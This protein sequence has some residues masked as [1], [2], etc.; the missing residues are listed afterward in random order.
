MLRTALGGP[1]TEQLPIWCWVIEHPEGVILV[2]TGANT[3]MLEPGYFTRWNPYFRRNVRVSVRPEEEIGPRLHSLGIEPGEVRRVVL[4]HL[5]LDHA[6]GLHHFPNAEILVSRE[7]HRIATGPLGKAAGYLP[8]RWPSWF[9][10]RL[11]DLELEP[12]GP[13][14]RSLALTQAGDVWL[15]G[16]EGHSAG[17]V[18]VVVLEK[19]RSLFLA[20]DASYT[21]ELM[22]EQAIDGVSPSGN[23]ARRTLGRILRYAEENQTVYLP[24]HDPASAERLAGRR[25][26]QAET[27]VS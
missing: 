9:A 19:G 18:S 13:F 24:G 10:P 14:P 15:V 11:V 16:T 17:H 7:E 6:G 1:W 23:A 26:A 3:R 25:T 21:E 4:T 20:G 27:A 22:L 5:H 2:D 8:H 12:F